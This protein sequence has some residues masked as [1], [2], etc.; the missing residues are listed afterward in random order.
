MKKVRK[1]SKGAGLLRR[2]A[3]KQLRQTRKRETDHPSAAKAGPVLV[4]ELEVHQIELEMQNEELMQSRAK[5]EESL[6]RYSELYDFSPAGYFTLDSEAKI[7]QVNLTGARVLG[8][9]RAQLENRRFGLFVSEPDR[10]VFNAFLTNAFESR[11]KES[12]ELALGDAADSLSCAKTPGNRRMVQIEGRVGEDG[13]ACRAVVIDITDRKMIEDTH[14][15]LLQSGWSGEDFFLSLA[16]YL[17]KALE[18]DYVCIDRLEGDCLAA[19][20]LAIYHNGRFEDNV[21]YALKDTPCGAV[22]GKTI[23]GFPKGVRHLFPRDLVLQEL[24]A[25]SYLGT[26]LW[27]SDGKPIGLIALIGRQPKASLRIAESILKMVAIRAAGELERRQAEEALQKAKDELEDRV[28]ERTYE[29][30]NRADQ[31]RALASELTQAEIRARKYLASVLHDDLQQLLVCAKFALSSALRNTEETKVRTSLG[32]VEDFLNQS[33]DKSRTLTAEI[34]PP[35]LSHG[36]L[37]D[38]LKWLAQWMHEK[39]GLTVDLHIE[40]N[41]ETPQDVRALLFLAVRE[42]LFNIVKHAGVSQAG[43][44]LERSGGDGLAIVVTDKGIGFDANLMSEPGG[45]ASSFGLLSIQERLQCFGGRFEIVSTP[46]QGTLMRLVAPISREPQG[47]M[48]KT[49][50]SIRGPI[51]QPSLAP[52]A[53]VSV[54]LVDDHRTLREGL[55]QLLRDAPDIKVVGEAGDGQQAVAMAR[56]LLPNVIIMDVN[57]P[58]MNGIEATRVIAEECPQ[59]RVIALSMYSEPEMETTMR[60]AGAV[61]YLIK[62]G[63]SADLIDAIR[64]CARPG[65][66]NA[67]AA[68]PA[69]IS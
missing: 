55:I 22:V 28:K 2:R 27:G 32:E 45:L 51:G 31:L 29:L 25:E 68:S 65:A 38:A 17:A 7:L 5:M 6:E 39:H 49:A 43:V 16:R 66:E 33:I 24:R 63:P 62:S 26:T 42:L 67:T 20:T 58:G 35:I 40:E 56:R 18:M 69:F 13:R 61:N 9:E 52:L 21:T 48:T 44:R 59:C 4:H 46:G 60:E 15:F 1:G 34:S 14:S 30:Q 12:C 36:G 64:S 54:L 23:C 10:P 57:L 19:R 37:V 8:M 47:E 11:A 3:E 50:P 53:P 41:V